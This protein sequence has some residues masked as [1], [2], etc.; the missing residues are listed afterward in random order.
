MCLNKK[1]YL[2]TPSL[3]NSW[4]Y[5]WEAPKNI[6][7]AEND[8]MSLED[9]RDLAMQKAYDDFI[10]TLNRISSEPNKYMQAGIEFEEEC[11]NGNTCI[12]PIIENGT[13]QIS[14]VK[15][16]TIDEIDFVMY[17]RLDVLKAGVIY[18]I[19]RIW[20][21]SPQKYFWSSQ[22]RFYLDLFPNAKYFEYLAFDGNKLHR[23]RYYRENSIPT[24]ERIKQFIQWLKENDL[25]DIYFNKWESKY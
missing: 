14:G 6:V 10:N 19:K 25:I 3:L 22:H 23:E 7:E 20:K 21:Y 5:I 9:K 4:L 18:D 16:V 15:D 17:G 8:I 1:K 11:Y 2:I 24:I 13:F 12:S